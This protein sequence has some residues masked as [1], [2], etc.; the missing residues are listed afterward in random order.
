[1]NSF[2]DQ[3][4]VILT[5]NKYTLLADANFYREDT[6]AIK[7]IHHSDHPGMEN[8]RLVGIGSL[9]AAGIRDTL[10]AMQSIYKIKI[11]SLSCHAAHQAFQ[12]SAFRKIERRWVIGSLRHVVDDLRINPSIQHRPG[13]NLLKKIT[14][15]TP[16]TGKCKQQSAGG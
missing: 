11:S 16:G 8:S 3:I 14:V 9:A 12:V 13:Y 6:L 7:Q 5:L 4:K 1:M 10:A 2:S 15:D